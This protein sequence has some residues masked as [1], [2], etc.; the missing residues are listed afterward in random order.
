MEEKVTKKVDK[1]ERYVNTSKSTIRFNGTKV[2][3]GEIVEAN[4]SDIAE[5]INK[6]LVSC[7]E[8]KSF[9]K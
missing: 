6:K 9:S 5:L 7:L 2:K 1:I 4:A 3:A 8:T